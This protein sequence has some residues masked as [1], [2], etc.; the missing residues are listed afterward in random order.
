MLLQEERET[1]VEYSRKMAESG[2]CPGTSGNL[3]ILERKSG[4]VAITPSGMDYMS[5]TPEDITVI[6][7][8]ANVIDGKRKPSSEWALHTEFYKAKPDISSVIHTH[9]MYACVFAAI[10]EPLR[11]VHFIIGAAGSNEIKCAPY[12]LFG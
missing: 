5:L 3:S 8:Y 4:Y 12:A 1:V 2:L 7:L 9:S 10:G 6:D 11:A